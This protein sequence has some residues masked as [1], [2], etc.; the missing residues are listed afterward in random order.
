M[1][2]WLLVCC[3]AVPVGVAI[4]QPA[5]LSSASAPADDDDDDDIMRCMRMVVRQLPLSRPANTRPP[6][7]ATPPPEAETA[8]QRA[9]MHDVFW[10][11][12]GA[13]IDAVGRWL[14]EENF[15]CIEQAY[16]DLN[17]PEVRFADGGAKVAYFA[18]AVA[19]F[20][21][22]RRGMTPTEIE[23]HMAR[24]RVAFPGSMLAQLLYPAMFSAAAWQIRGDGYA[25]QISPTE[26]DAFRSI[27]R[28]AFEALKATSASA[29][30]QLLWHYVA[31]VIVA[32]NGASFD[33]L[34]AFSMDSLRLFPEHFTLVAIP[35]N[36]MTARWGGSSQRLENYAQAALRATQARS[37]RRAYAF[38]YLTA[39]RFE[40][41][42]KYAEIRQADLRQGFVELAQTASYNGIS[43]LHQYACAYRD[44][45][46][47]LLARSLWQE[48]ARKPQLRPA[49]TVSPALCRLW[50]E[51]TPGLR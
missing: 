20:V 31:P 7:R 13:L 39:E 19:S 14:G 3:S 10:T 41:L 48:Y 4:A 40:Q 6:A 15:A 29:R 32:D 8:Q 25:D 28:R 30:E 33:E 45:E 34:S 22:Q 37:G 18:G 23:A 12:E 27:N 36:R 47:F 5:Q 11:N 49:Q 43:W 2:R 35:A 24:W 9:A 21:R 38:A 44:A 50:I 1:I 46:A 51:Q 17:R 42:P 16:A 26:W